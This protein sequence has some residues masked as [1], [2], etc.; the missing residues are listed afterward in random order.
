MKKK[1]LCVLILSAVVITSLLLL[2]C[3]LAPAA[4]V[5]RWIGQED[6]ARAEAPFWSVQTRLLRS[7][8]SEQSFLRLAH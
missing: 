2:S 7:C 6:F 8:R 5:V 1:G 4:E 3:E